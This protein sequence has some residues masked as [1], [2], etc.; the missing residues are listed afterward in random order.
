MKEQ[1][2]APRQLTPREHILE[3]SFVPQLMYLAVLPYLGEEVARRELS[4]Q[5]PGE[6]DRADGSGA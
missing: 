2:G 6:T 5:R 1:P 3:H 4:I